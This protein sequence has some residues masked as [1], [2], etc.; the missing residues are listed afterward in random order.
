MGRVAEHNQEV[1]ISAEYR[2]AEMTMFPSPLE[3]RMIKFLVEHSIH[4]EPQKIFYIY[5]EDGWIERYFI[6]D[7]F[8][9]DRNI[10]IEVD[11]KKY[12][13]H[14]SQK[15]KARDR[16]IQE[17][18]PE[19]KILRYTWGDLSDDSKMMDLLWELS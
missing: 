17:H 15:D 18:Y 2:A 10:V 9:P 14:H 4:Y 12:H 19:V 5:K 7:F 16:L 6:A 1:R 13:E 8:V 3:E 11:G